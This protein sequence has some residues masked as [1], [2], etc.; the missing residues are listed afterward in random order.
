MD[1]LNL[2]LDSLNTQN[3]L[4]MQAYVERGAAAKAASSD[5][6]GW[7]DRIDSLPEFSADQLTRMHGQLIALGFLKFEIAGRSVGLRYQIS[8]RGKQAI[9]RALSA[10]SDED[11]D[12]GECLDADP[13]Q[14][15]AA[16]SEAA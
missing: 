12:A 5:Y 9:E 1:A 15:P 13:D 6:D 4:V 8:P 16:L 14:D 11:E 10:T 2:Q 3:L 7:L